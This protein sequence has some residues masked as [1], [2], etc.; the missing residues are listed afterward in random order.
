MY[1]A[2]LLSFTTVLLYWHFT[3]Q[4]PSR[5]PFKETEKIPNDFAVSM[6]DGDAALLNAA[7]QEFTQ[8]L[9]KANIS[10]FMIGGTLLGSYRHHGRIPWDDDVDLALNQ[11]EKQNIRQLFSN[12]TTHTLWIAD[13]EEDQW[14]FFPTNG[15]KVPGFRY[16]FHRAPYVDVFW[17]ND[18][19]DNITFTSLWF[20]PRFAKSD[21]FP[22]RRRPFGKLLL[23]AP[24]NTTAFFAGE[25][26]H[27]DTCVSRSYNHL[28]ET[29]VHNVTTMPCSRL[30]NFY[31]F[32][33]RRQRLSG[34]NMT[35][36]IESL[37]HKGAVLNEWSYIDND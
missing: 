10:Y 26:F 37:I 8:T 31:P 23:P 28:H 6:S 18:T 36:I 15:Q 33:Q 16:Q 27:I 3:V 34:S 35:L 9:E 25:K 17:F 12:F 4:Q 13:K 30:A 11:V 7:L 5:Y 20:S 21:V 32:V 2:F 29:G 14:K 24:C 22:L 19:E 1:A